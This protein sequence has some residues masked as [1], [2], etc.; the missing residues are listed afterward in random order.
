MRKCVGCQ[1]SKPQSE[2]MRF[3]ADGPVIKADPERRQPGRGFYLCRD[4]A[5]L[6]KAFKR[7]AFNR[8]CRSATDNEMIRTIVESSL[9]AT[10]EE[11]NV[12]KS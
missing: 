5:C 10:K 7:K 3:T 9:N 8:I 6:D 4:S 12:K 2:L 1:Q 11:M